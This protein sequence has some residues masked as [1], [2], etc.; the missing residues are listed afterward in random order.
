MPPL[1]LTEQGSTLRK[2]GQ[3]FVVT[4]DGQTLL[5]V[6]AFKV[7]AVL[8][9]GNVQ[10]TTQAIAFLLES[11]IDTG[12]LS[13]RGRLKGKLIPLEG[14]NVLLRVK[15]FERA[16]SEGF[17][18]SV[19]RRIVS[20]KLRNA[21]ALLMRHARNHPEAELSREIDELAV[22]ANRV[23]AAAPEEPTLDRV[24]GLEGQG[25]AVYF[26]GFAKMLRSE[27]RF[28]GRSRR[29]PKD[30]I[31]GL[32]S[33]GYSLLTQELIGLI[34]AHGFDPF[35]GFYH[36][37]RYGRAGLALDLVEEFRHPL[38]DALVLRLVN[39]RVVQSDDFSRRSE[40]GAVMLKPEALKRYLAQ[41]ERQMQRPLH[42][43]LP[44]DA[45][46]E[47]LRLPSPP[48]WRDLFRL[49]VRRMARAVRAGDGSAYDPWRV[50]G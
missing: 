12:F 25:S 36:E 35:V 30:P 23:E 39:K 16:R 18:A 31:N 33:L 4:K 9:F 47:G 1:Y 44:A 20:A 8:I 19:A 3:R 15:Q 14:K 49:Q 5:T 2:E 42:V 32:L 48:S 27:L 50:E 24:R 43:R 28:E 37:L 11:G 17:K 45:E 7:D 38:I 6:P 40:D 29:P 46:A 22:L 10:L 41:Y 13:L 21:R 26:R 34:S